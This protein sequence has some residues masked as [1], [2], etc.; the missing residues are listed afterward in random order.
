MANTIENLQPEDEVFCVM[1]LFMSTDLAFFDSDWDGICKTCCA[2]VA[3]YHPTWNCG[4]QE[5]YGD[6]GYMIT[7]VALKASLTK[8]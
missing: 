6:S 5:N 3:N 1:A 2:T 8:P 4:S 7:K